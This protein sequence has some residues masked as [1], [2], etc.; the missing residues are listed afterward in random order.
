MALMQDRF[1][2]NRV[3]LSPSSNIWGSHYESAQAEE[4]TDI[5]GSSQL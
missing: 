2:F 1:I 3:A 5:G 4:K